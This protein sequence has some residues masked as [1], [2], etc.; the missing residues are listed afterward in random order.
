M[1]ALVHTDAYKFEYKDF[2]TPAP[3][4]N[5]LLIRVKA[6]GICGSDIHGATG[7][8]GRRQPPIIMGHEAAGIVEKIGA[9]VTKFAIGDRI[10]FDSTV[11]C[12]KCSFCQ[13]G[14][15]IYQLQK[16]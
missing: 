11:Y 3:T 9:N 13:N 14:S 12:G 1:K 8:T 5:E 15:E 6:V 7:K 16:R 2:E 10:T 4:D